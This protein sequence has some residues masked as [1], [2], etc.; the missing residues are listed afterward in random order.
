M[1]KQYEPDHLEQAVA[2]FVEECGEALAAAGKLLRWGP[3]SVNPEL[4]VEQQE[5]NIDWLL[6][7]MRDVA[8]A[9][10]RVRKFVEMGGGA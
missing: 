9:I 5:A 4:P 2:Y 10:K 1:K 3:E 6:R 7:E 8:T